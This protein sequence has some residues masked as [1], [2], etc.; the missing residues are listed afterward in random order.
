MHKDFEKFLRTVVYDKKLN[1]IQKSLDNLKTERMLTT[2][3]QFLLGINAVNNRKL[4]SA[5][6][7]FANSY[8][9][10]LL[11][12][13][14]DRAIFWLY[15]LSKNTIY[16]EELAKSF[17]ANIYSLYAKELLNITPDNLVFKIDMKIKPS[18]YDIY[19]A[20]SW[21]EVTEDSKKI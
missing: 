17:E 13:D 14:K 15:L 11:R 9:I 18:S 7:F 4:E 20:F 16:L 21:L 8:D 6:Q 1:N 10:A 5:K 19:D 2:N 12:G 3:L